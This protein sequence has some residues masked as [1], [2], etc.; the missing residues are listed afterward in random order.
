MKGRTAIIVLIVVMA[1]LVGSTG[2]RQH[3]ARNLRYRNGGRARSRRLIRPDR[4]P[5][6]T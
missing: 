6:S 4:N 3:N 5:L 2:R 1:A